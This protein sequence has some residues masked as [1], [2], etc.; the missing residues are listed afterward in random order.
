MQ[1]D[2]RKNCQSDFFYN[3]FVMLGTFTL[4]SNEIVYW[5]VLSVTACIK[6]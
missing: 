3:S 5:S 6:A 2:Q 1:V 4:H